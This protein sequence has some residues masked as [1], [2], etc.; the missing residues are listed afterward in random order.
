[1]RIARFSMAI[2]AVLLC[3]S[4]TA[5]QAPMAQSTTATNSAH[6]REERRRAANREGMART[7]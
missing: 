3:G 2:A 5:P 6:P 1:M 7:P 4:A